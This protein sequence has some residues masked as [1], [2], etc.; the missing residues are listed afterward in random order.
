MPY[1]AS[2]VIIPSIVDLGQILNNR[3]CERNII[4]NSNPSNANKAYIYI[5]LLSHFSRDKI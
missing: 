2:G 4:T 5:K 1:I 3:A